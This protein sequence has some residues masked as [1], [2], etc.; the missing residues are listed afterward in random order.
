MV[1]KNLAWQPTNIGKVQHSPPKSHHIAPFG[2]VSENI[3]ELDSHSSQRSLPSDSEMKKVETKKESF[4]LD[5]S[6][7]KTDQK[8]ATLD[9][10][11]T[12][13]MQAQIYQRRPSD[14]LG[15]DPAIAN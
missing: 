8:A 4:E 13:T 5:L 11:S 10:P 6:V 12:A 2:I 3:S 1:N 7:I 14:D 15:I 9:T